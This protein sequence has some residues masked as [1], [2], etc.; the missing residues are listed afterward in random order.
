[1]I[2]VEKYRD[3]FFYR[4]P[5]QLKEPYCETASHHDFPYF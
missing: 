1:M 5:S 3:L 4:F 2:P